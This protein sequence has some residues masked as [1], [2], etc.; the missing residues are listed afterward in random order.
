MTYNRIE[1]AAHLP[2]TGQ[3]NERARERSDLDFK[4]FADPAKVWEH[5]KD[6]AAFAN[7]LGGVLLLG[8]DDSSGM[9]H[10]PGLNGQDAKDVQA[11]YEAAAKLC[12]PSPVVDVIPIPEI[13]VVAVN[14]D[15]FMDQVVAAPAKTRDRSGKEHL[16]DTAWVFPI[17]VASQTDF[18]KPENLAMYMNRDVRRAVLLLSKILEASRKNVRVHC[19]SWA[20]STSE[21]VRMHEFELS[22]G[23]VSVDRNFLE[24]V[25]DNGASSLQCRIPLLDVEDV[26]E[27]KPGSWEV[28]VSGRVNVT[29]GDAST[30]P[31]LYYHPMPRR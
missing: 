14:V 17:R 3:L 21:A 28:R 23:E 19:H 26:W 24:L 11:V 22:V 10:Y 29:S 12:S 1:I 25:K 31:S 8:A 15:P 16:H 7:A 4:T 27:S 30:A 18:I 6:I 20:S 13:R 2:P 9:L 5:A